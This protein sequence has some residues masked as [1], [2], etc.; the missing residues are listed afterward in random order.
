MGVTW[1]L[2]YP[3]FF[4]YFIEYHNSN[5][6]VILGGYGY[7]S[8]FSISGDATKVV[9]VPDYKKNKKIHYFLTRIENN[10]Y[11]VHRLI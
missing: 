11:T 6:F 7:T 2:H 8:S 1:Y 9:Q 5:I 4:S 3:F 10:V